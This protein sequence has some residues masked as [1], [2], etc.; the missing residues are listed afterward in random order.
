MEMPDGKQLL[1][2]YLEMKNISP[3]KQYNPFWATFGIVTDES[4]YEA[5]GGFEH[6]AYD[7]KVDLDWIQLAKNIPRLQQVL[8][9]D[10]EI[11]SG[12]VVP[13]W[14]GVVLP[15]SVETDDVEIGYADDKKF[16]VR[17]FPPA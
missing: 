15:R 2:A 13:R 6:P 1:V 4:S 17:W 7:S 10:S 3:E 11:P 14:F 5:V 8:I 16:D 9:H 12:S